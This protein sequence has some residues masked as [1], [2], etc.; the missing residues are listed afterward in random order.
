MCD[1]HNEREVKKLKLYAY[2]I[3]FNC[4][5]C[6]YGNQFAIN[7]NLC[8]MAI[9]NFPFRLE[10]LDHYG[11]ISGYP[12]KVWDILDMGLGRRLIARTSEDMSGYPGK[13]WDIYMRHG[14]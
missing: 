14:T 8:H 11:Y 3:Y 5:D 2:L 7:T 9:V 12:G 13:V 10:I 6:V 1:L 4:T